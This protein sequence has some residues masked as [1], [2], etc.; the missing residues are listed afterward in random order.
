MAKSLFF[1]ASLLLFVESL[2]SVATTRSLLDLVGSYEPIKNIDDPHIQSL[3]KFA[4]DEHNK[5]AKT[6]LKFQ[7][8]ISGKL[9][10][11]AGTNYELE[12]TALEGT[13]SRIYGTLIFTDLENKNHLINF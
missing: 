1:M 11:V 5:Q 9:Q 6:Q 13:V 4:V 8:V 7:K 12:L 10:I 2:S 3:G